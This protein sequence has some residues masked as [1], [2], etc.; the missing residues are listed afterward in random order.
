MNKRIVRLGIFLLVCY[1][2]LF[3]MLNWLQVFAADSLKN[4]EFN[5]RATRENLARP[6]GTVETADGVVVARSVEVDDA[7]E[8]QREYPE[9]ALYGHITGFFPINGRARGIEDVYNDEL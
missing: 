7:L 8:F 1:V 4:N 5:A 9:G 3:V 6:R 2:A